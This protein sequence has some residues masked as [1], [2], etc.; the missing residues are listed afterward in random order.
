MARVTVED[1][2]EHV[3]NR[4]DLV[5]R[6]SRRARQMHHG[7]E[8]LLPDENDKATVIALREIADGLITDEVLDAADVVPIDDEEEP[9]Q[10]PYGGLG[11][12]RADDF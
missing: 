8:P 2:L 9:L 11:D 7:V 6:A 12:D 10:M 5:M 4:F 3:D 1:C